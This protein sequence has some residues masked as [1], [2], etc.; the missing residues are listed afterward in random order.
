MQ[1]IADYDSEATRSRTPD[2]R[3]YAS[4]ESTPNA[5]SPSKQ[6]DSF[7]NTANTDML[8][9][10]GYHQTAN[11]GARSPQASKEMRPQQAMNRLKNIS[12][13][14]LTMLANPVHMRE[15]DVFIRV[16]EEFLQDLKHLKMRARGA[17]SGLITVSNPEA[18]TAPADSTPPSVSDSPHAPAPKPTAKS[19]ISA[20]RARE[21]ANTTPSK[22]KV[23]AATAHHIDVEEHRNEAA[24][25]AEQRR[26]DA[27]DRR[28]DKHS[29]HRTKLAKAQERV[30]TTKARQQEA[31]ERK[32]EASK[33]RSD[34]ATAKAEQ[35]RQQIVEKSIKHAS[36]VEEVLFVNEVTQQNKAIKLET[37]QNEADINIEARREE[38][39]LHSKERTEAHQAVLERSKEINQQKVEKAQQ[40]SHQWQ[41]QVKRVEELKKTEVGTKQQRNE[42][43]EKRVQQNLQSANADAETKKQ[44]TEVRLNQSVQNRE[45]I[46][47]ARAQQAAKR[48]EKELKAKERREDKQDIAT[49]VARLFAEEEP[50]AVE[51]KASKLAKINAMMLRHGKNFVERYQKESPLGVKELNKSR[52]RAQVAR[53]A[54][55]GS[56]ARQ[57]LK[58]LSTLLTSIDHEYIRYFGAYDQLASILME[59]RRASDSETFCLAAE[60]LLR[61][62]GDPTEGVSHIRCFV[63]CGHL[64]SMATIVFEELHALHTADES[65]VLCFS[66]IILSHCTDF[67]LNCDAALAVH[68]SHIRDHAAELLQL[69]GVEK[70]CFGA[71]ATPPTVTI[72]PCLQ[73]ALL[74]LSDYIQIRAKRKEK[75]NLAATTTGAAPPAATAAVQPAAPAEVA[76]SAHKVISSLLSLVQNILTPPN[77]KFEEHALSIPATLVV[78]VSFRIANNLFRGRA[79][80]VCEAMVTE[81]LRTLIFHTSTAFFGFVAA[82]ST[83]LERIAPSAK[84]GQSSRSFEDALEFGIT[85]Q[86]IPRSMATTK[87]VVA[88]STSS[89]SNLSSMAA[90]SRGGGL[91]GLGFAIHGPTEGAMRAALHELLLFLGL[92]ALAEPKVQELFSWGK[93]R[94]LLTTIISAL[95]ASYFTL[96]QHILFPTLVTLLFND[97]RNMTIADR[98]MN[99][100]AIHA[101]LK[102]EMDSLTNKQQ[103]KLKAE[104]ASAPTAPVKKTPASWADE[105]DSELE[106]ALEEAAAAHSKAKLS[107]LRQTKSIQNSASLWKMENRVPP[108][109][110]AELLAFFTPEAK[111]DSEESD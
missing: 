89:R 56:L 103:K 104:A 74:V 111:T 8:N 65:P 39:R 100:D 99:V 13:D 92:A 77:G 106:D 20:L 94:P 58:E 5:R 47:E 59:A 24:R 80:E 22:A 31:A 76:M 82:N 69:C 107:L 98:D 29:E 41:E 43:R 52:L 63:R 96:A 40:R 84:D 55:G 37:K 38:H 14:V 48:K 81:E 9:N 16:S 36:H 4:G 91:G 3:G 64:S 6:L 73:N 49:P 57:P 79:A 60:F 18:G 28:T 32:L 23:V 110:W 70:Y 66:L 53:M 108:V 83:C 10:S 102:Q 7:N 2:N 87:G 1:D 71:A 67:V 44:R 51:Q 97:S 88:G 17:R 105:T 90:S 50:E 26:Q 34:R 95:P 109:M 72:M 78:L 61:I 25:K 93:S 30:E 45:S 101:F 46:E 21:S 62:F 15:V 35:Q 75:P 19:Y 33:E 86:H 11:L 54:S 42:E 85:L 27:E 68:I 12:A